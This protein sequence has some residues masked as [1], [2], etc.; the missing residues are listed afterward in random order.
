MNTTNWYQ[1]S[2]EEVFRRLET[3]NRGLTSIE[4]RERLKIFGPNELE[5]RKPSVLMRFL[6]QFNN[7]LVYVLLVA[8]AIT[9]TLTLRPLV[10]AHLG[11]PHYST[12]QMTYD[13]RRLRRKGFIQRLD[14][15]HHYV[16]T[17]L[18]RRLAFF[19]A[20]S[21]AR[22]LQPGLR[23]LDPSSPHQNPRLAQAWLR[24]DHAL[25]SFIHDARLAP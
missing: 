10:A 23:Q 9:G 1:L 2:V 20:K 6:R 5:S 3:G 14:G 8:A 12:R 21:Y 13:L 18:G 7:P 4:A 11:Q 16:V 19:F 24:F 25:D 15:T 22:I 17:L